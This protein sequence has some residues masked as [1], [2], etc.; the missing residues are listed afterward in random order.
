[1]PNYFINMDVLISFRSVGL[2]LLQYRGSRLAVLEKYLDLFDK[3]KEEDGHTKGLTEYQ[4]RLPGELI[5]KGDYD[6]LVSA[7][8]EEYLGYSRQRQTHLRVTRLTIICHSPIGE[9]LV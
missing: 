7:I 8:E 9:T 3:Q 4:K 5:A 2:R 1:M 6:T